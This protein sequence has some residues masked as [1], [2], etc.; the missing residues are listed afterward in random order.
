MPP[1]D[2][3]LLMPYAYAG[4]GYEALTGI[5]EHFPQEESVSEYGLPWYRVCMWNIWERKNDPADTDPIKKQINRMEQNLIHVDDESRYIRIQIACLQRCWWL[6]P[7][8]VDL[9]I[10]GIGSGQ[11]KLSDHVSCEPPWHG[12]VEILRYRRGHPAPTGG[13]YRIFADGYPD[14][15]PRQSLCRTYMTILTWWSNGGHIDY[16]RQELPAYA[17]LAETV[18]RRLGPPNKLKMLY[19][20]KLRLTIGCEA[21]PD[22][23]I[24]NWINIKWLIAIYNEAI[25]KELN[26]NPDKIGGL[27][28]ETGLCHHSFFRHI[29]HQ[30]AAI[31]TGQRVKLPGEGSERKRIHD[32]VTTYV[33]ILGSWLDNR[34]EE[35]ADEIWPCRPLIQRVYA[36]LGEKSNIKRW[37]VAC[38]WKHLQD[39]QRKHGRGMLDKQPELFRLSDQAFILQ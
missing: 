37:L 30:I 21:F 26:G 28:S 38:L 16:L 6:F 12:L 10:Q 3:P 14:L 17:E 15:S 19:V 36:D 4:Y 18:Y 13:T 1:N 5:N 22:N 31:G 23:G 24:N 34:S 35:Q 32:T 25:E 29:D 2:L 39:N 9:V 20:E 27:I 11:V 8:N 33:H 7:D